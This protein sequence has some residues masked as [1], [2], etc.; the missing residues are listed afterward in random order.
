MMKCFVILEGCLLLWLCPALQAMT[1][2]DEPP[3]CD[4]RFFGAGLI[5]IDC[6]SRDLSTIP[7]FSHLTDRNITLLDFSW[8][9]MTS[10]EA[11]A[12]QGL[13]LVNTGDLD[14][15]LKLNANPI[16]SIDR[17]AFRG[18]QTNGL[19]LDIK[20]SDLNEFP[21][22]ALQNAPNLTSLSFWYSR[23]TSIPAAAFQ[24]LQGLYSLDLTGNHVGYL[25]AS[26]FE[27][28]EASLKF[29]TLRDMGLIAFPQSALRRLEKLE[30][31]NLDENL[32]TSLSDTSL[33]GL[34]T[35]ENLILSLQR[36]QISSISPTAFRIG[37]FRLTK[38]YL[39]VNNLNNLDFLY[40]PC[41]RLYSVWMEVDVNQNPVAC[42]CELISTLAT[43]F[44]ISKG[45]CATG[46]GSWVSNL[47]SSLTI[48]TTRYG[49]LPNTTLD[50]FWYHCYNTTV[51]FLSC[52][53][54]Q[55]PVGNAAN[56]NWAR[57]TYVIQIYIALF[58]VC[59]Y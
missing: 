50:V 22:E 49:Q 10:L 59:V 5:S 23:L 39:A 8:N 35:A 44:Y 34:A 30:Y 48:S 15:Q 7:D 42:S 43:G 27:G 1:L 17:D 36:N 19:R 56:L 12:F 58:V 20:Y 46:Q 13:H 14:G 37:Q 26:V 40:E 45:S 31:L 33:Q 18:I 52:L 29:M 51:P 2:C 21:T 53:Y 6:K 25:V 9:Q 3:Y 47:Y 32:L 4:C 41:T 38:I 57:W 55:D 11:S 54:Y 28:L 16:S 24:G